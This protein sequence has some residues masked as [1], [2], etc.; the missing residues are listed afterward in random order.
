MF[1]GLCNTRLSIKPN[2]V[3]GAAVN[4]KTGKKRGRKSAKEKAENQNRV[5]RSERKKSS[6]SSR[7]PS[8]DLSEPDSDDVYKPPKDYKSST[9]RTIFSNALIR[10]GTKSTKD[11]SLEKEKQKTIKD[12][13]DKPLVRKT[14]GLLLQSAGVGLL[15]KAKEKESPEESGGLTTQLTSPRRGSGISFGLWGGHL[16][17]EQSII[18]STLTSTYDDKPGDSLLIEDKK[19]ESRKKVFSNW[20]GDF[21]KKNLD[22]RANTNRI[23]EKLTKSA[24]DEDNGV[25]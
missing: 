14:P 10:A 9:T 7:E 2:Y 5:E 19:E 1:L 3:Q 24:G 4:Q 23:L 8:P 17:V 12:L 13:V 21:F 6:S 16:P 22:F 18:S 11:S 20:G 25:S 15:N